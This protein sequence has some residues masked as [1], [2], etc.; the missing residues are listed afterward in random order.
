M[1]G[2]EIV[3]ADGNPFT[4][5]N[6]K[7]IDERVNSSLF[8]VGQG[9]PDYGS[10]IAQNFIW[11]LENFANSTPPVNPL[12][13]Q[14]WYDKAHKRMSF[15]NGSAWEYY[16]IAENSSAALFDMA[17]GTQNLDFTVTGTTAIFTGL[18]PS[19][20]YCATYLVM[21][22][23]GFFTATHSATINLS[24]ISTGDVLASVVIPIISSNNFVKLMMNVEPQIIIGT[25]TLNLNITTA[26]TD[27]LLN[28]DVYVFGFTL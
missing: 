18:D 27:G 25:N 1:S 16:A 20:K 11:M 14:E 6:V 3:L 19:K 28:Y 15:Y 21:I 12:V 17:T 10:L 24:V 2:Y 8:L 4:T 7:T 26:A 23:R 22:P 9:I 5:I 13:G